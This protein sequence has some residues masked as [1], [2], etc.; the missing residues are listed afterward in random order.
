MEKNTV[1]LRDVRATKEVEL[2]SFKGSK[3]VVYSSLL[4]GDLD[5]VDLTSKADVMGMKSLPKLI[6]EW[7]FV[8]ESQNPLAITEENIKKLPAIDVAFLVDEIVK[9]TSSEK[10]S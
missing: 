2:P 9:L 4:V 3:V 8:D 5:G 6:K 1:V 10:K 7:N